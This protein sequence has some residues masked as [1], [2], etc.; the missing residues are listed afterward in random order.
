MISIS[1]NCKSNIYSK[2]ISNIKKKFKIEHIVS[3]IIIL[4]DKVPTIFNLDINMIKNHHPN[5]SIYLVLD[6]KNLETKLLDY[7]KLNYKL[8]S[9][10]VS[11]FLI[12]KTK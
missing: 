3:K 2:F 8:N 9:D 5:T 6:I 12:S 7:L 11:K 10:L 1:T 4:K